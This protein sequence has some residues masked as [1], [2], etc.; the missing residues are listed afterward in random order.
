MVIAVASGKGGTGKTTLACALA[1]AL[2][3]E[4]ALVDC[5]VE[6]PNC[7]LFLKPEINKE[8]L[9][10]VPLPVINTSLCN[11]C[12][13]CQGICEYNALKVFNKKPV[14]FD[15]LCHSCG[16]CALICPQKAITEDSRPVGKIRIGK[17]NGSFFC[18]GVMNLGEPT[19]VRLIKAVKKLAPPDKDIIIDCP[20]GTSCPMIAAV[21]GAD[22][23]LLVSEPTPFGLS[24]LKLAVETIEK[25]NIPIAVVINKYDIGNDE[26][27]KWCNNKGIDII[28]K[29]PFDRN[30]AQSYSRGETLVVS[31]PE[32]LSIL[33]KI[34]A[35][36]KERKKK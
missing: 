13:K 23:C 28:L 16:G 32:Y 6:E 19:P 2:S 15:H 27:E 4:V 29:I 17:F 30:I 9:F 20:P 33:R 11:G 3:P 10:S 21:E 7:A 24:D 12:G 26:M 22:F 35:D 34:F 18:D 5:D 1:R 36:I 31:R 14:L 8:V 25:L